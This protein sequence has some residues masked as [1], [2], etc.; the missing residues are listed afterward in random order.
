MGNSEAWIGL[1]RGVEGSADESE[2]WEGSTDRGESFT[3]Q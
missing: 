3:D 2:G 1:H